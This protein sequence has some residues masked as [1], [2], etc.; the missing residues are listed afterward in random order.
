MFDYENYNKRELKILAINR[1]ADIDYNDFMKIF[2]ECTKE[3]YSL[4]TIDA[5]LPASDPLRS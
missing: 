4:L 5:T 3:R 1:S 2:R